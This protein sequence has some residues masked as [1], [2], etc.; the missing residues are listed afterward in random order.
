MRVQIVSLMVGLLLIVAGT[1]YGAEKTWRV[2]DVKGKAGLVA[3]DGA[4]ISLSNEKN[5]LQALDTGS[6]VKVEG[7]GKV[8]IVSLKT[9]MAYE[10][11]DDSEAV[12]EDKEVRALKG[13]VAAKKGYTLPKG[14]DGKMGGIVMRGGNT[15]S[16]LKVV[17][18]ANTATLDLDPVF[19]WENACEG[20]RQVTVTLLSDERV[21]HTAESGDSSMRIPAGVVKPGVRYMWLIDGGVNFDMASAVFTVLPEEERSEVMAQI[22]AAAGAGPDDIAG[23]IAHVYYLEGMGLAQMARQESEKIRKRYPG[24]AALKDLP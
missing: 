12:V 14:K 23:M 3:P 16:C 6:R 24:A 19:Q 18:P 15:R 13:S 17:S 20:L 11:A 10:I 1:V 7:K 22:A 8:V 21:V 5:L 9:R 2:F 4:R